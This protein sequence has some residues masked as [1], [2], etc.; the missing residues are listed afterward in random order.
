MV[1]LFCRLLFR[2]YEYVTKRTSTK[3]TKMKKLFK[4]VLI[5]ILLL[6]LFYGVVLLRMHVFNPCAGDMSKKSY[7]EAKEC[8]DWINSKDF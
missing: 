7:A 3:G 6:A 8:A 1:L 4:L 2:H 5:A